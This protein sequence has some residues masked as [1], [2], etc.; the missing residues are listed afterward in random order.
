MLNGEDTKLKIKNNLRFA[1]TYLQYDKEIDTS[2]AT[3]D[4]EVDG[5]VASY[6][7]SMIYNLNDKFTNNFTLANTYIKRIYGATKN[8]G[9]PIQDNYYGDR[10]ALSYLGNYNINLDNSIIF[11]FEPFSVCVSIFTSGQTSKTIL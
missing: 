11:G 4:E 1:D 7:M 9:N 10:Y 3:H 6:N 5:T 2:S 8:S